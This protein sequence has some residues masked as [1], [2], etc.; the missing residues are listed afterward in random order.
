M[1]YKPYLDQK[2]YEALAG[3]EIKGKC[4]QV[5]GFD[6]MLDSQGKA[7]VLEVNPTPSMNI[8]LCKE[9]SKGLLK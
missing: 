7:W 1:A 2:A 5:V 9:G 8:N 4:F 6:V 3:G